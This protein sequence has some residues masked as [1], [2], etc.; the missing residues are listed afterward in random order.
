VPAVPGGPKGSWQEVIWQLIES[1]AAESGVMM[2]LVTPELDSGPVITYCTYP[3]R[4]K[5]FD[6]LW[7]QSNERTVDELKKEEGD[8]NALFQLIRRHGLAREFPLIVSTLRA[9]GNGE[10][11]I[12]AG[13]LF[14]RKGR[15][16]SGY[17]LTHEVNK[18]LE[19]S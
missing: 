6:D 16:I 11:K 12:K 19:L 8:K 10:V 1:K 9:F 4:G 2:H 3:I 17:N 15:P 7:R 13:R 5:P 18:A 14:D